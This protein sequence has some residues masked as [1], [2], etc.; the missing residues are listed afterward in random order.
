MAEPFVLRP[1]ALNL[2]ELRR[3]AGGVIAVELDPACGDAIAAAEGVIARAIAEGERI[4]GVTTG[5]GS[6]A[7]TTI[8]ADQVSELQRRLVLSHSAGTGP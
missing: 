6:L 1:G 4:Y 3:L 8:S 5:F 7:R 2:A